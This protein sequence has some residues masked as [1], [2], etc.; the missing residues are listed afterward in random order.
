MEDKLLEFILSQQ[1]VKPKDV[2]EFLGISRQMTHR[3][4]KS[5][6]QKNRIS[7]IGSAPNVFYKINERNQIE[8]NTLSENDRN[9]LE[10]NFIE[11][12]NAGKFLRGVFAFQY[13]CEKRNLPLDKTL[14]EYK[15]TLIKYDAYKANSVISGKVKLENT[16]GFE[17]IYLED[18]F[19]LDFYAIERF[20]KTLLG[21]LIHFGKQ[22]QSRRLLDEIVVITKPKVLSLIK[23]LKV[24]AIA[25]IPPTISRQVQ[26]M[27]VLENGYAISLPKIKLVKV[28]GEIVVPQKALSKIKD[29]IENTQ[30][31]I[32]VADKRT[33]NSV[34]L[35][36]DAVGSGATL[37]E[38]AGKL[39][40]K[41]LASRVFGL[42][43]TGSYKG[44]EVITEA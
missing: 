16:K 32:M 38:T 11:I 19:Y 8:N 42:A 33:F 17:Q 9:F 27:T 23:S 14:E 4:L 13:W 31:S 25:Y 24:D 34:L 7:K 5:L 39:L 43:I 41:S 30:Q 6:L 15:L 2:S 1:E 40:K 3:Y 29:R 12:T 21:K 18:L 35:I 44:F 22:S 20:G 37:N 10:Q 26:I 36:D 28:K